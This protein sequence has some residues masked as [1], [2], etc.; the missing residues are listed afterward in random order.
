MAM[1]KKQKKQRTTKYWQDRAK[2]EWEW[3]KQQLKND[4]A[5]NRKIQEQ[6]EEALASIDRDMD[7]DC[8]QLAKRNKTT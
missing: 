3:Q 1:P 2:K 6:Y 5:F 8:N 4:E 7:A